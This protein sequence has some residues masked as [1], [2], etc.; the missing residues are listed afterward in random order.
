MSTK[1]VMYLNE[2]IFFENLW[3]SWEERYWAIINK[4]MIITIF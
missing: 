2:Y 1:V 3:E 4:N